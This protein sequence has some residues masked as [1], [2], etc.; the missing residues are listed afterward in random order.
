[1]RAYV[2][3][4]Y[5]G[6]EA[7]AL[8]DVAT[9]VPGPGHMLIKVRAAGLNPVDYKMRQGKLRL[10]FR[11]RLP[12]IAGCEVAGTVVRAGSGA[13]RFTAGDRVYS[14]VDAPGLGAFAEFVCVPEELVALMPQSLGFAE[15]AGL[16]LAG[17]TALQAL[18]DELRIQPG[19]RLFISGG[20]GG[21]GTLAIQLAK[22]FGA[23]VTTTASPRGHAL[24]RELGADRVVDYT[25]ENFAHMLEGFD[26]ALDA[27]GGRTLTRVFR[28]L[29]R[30]GRIVSVA[31]IPE[32]KTAL[33]DLHASRAVAILFWVVSL[34]VRLRAWRAG[35]SYR[36][37]F[38]HASGDDLRFLA[39]LVDEGKVRPV[40]DSTY[41]LSRISDA[42]AALEMG[43][44]KGKII[45]TMDDDGS[46]A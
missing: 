43:R 35:V 36:Y 46:P 37:L 44:A 11:P 4:R 27:V 45:V 16:P 26:A 29:R 33:Q 15:A 3:T 22:Y 14:R 40:V 28:I 8:R 20:A 10:L 17:L 9:P 24:V 13:N 19:S 38:M 23:E 7:M 25:R 18:R 41:P 39:G 34:G 30:G 31:G 5:G 12:F 32:P 42:F 21:V 2:I 1:M 6:P